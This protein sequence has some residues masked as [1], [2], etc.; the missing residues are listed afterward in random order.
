MNSRWHR[1][2]HGRQSAGGAQ[3]EAGGGGRVTPMASRSFGE[4]LTACSNRQTVA[5]K[6]RETEIDMEAP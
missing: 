1:Y 3:R 6:S 4:N 2:E 5:M